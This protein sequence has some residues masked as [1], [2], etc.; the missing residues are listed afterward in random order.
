MGIMLSLFLGKMKGAL[1][2]AAVASAFIVGVFLY[3]V[4]TQKTRQRV[5]ELKRF[6]ET[7]DEI[8]SVDTDLSRKRRL[9]RLRRNG[10]IR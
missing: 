3:G 4:R 1:V 8:N 7:T 10:T 2:A 9:K 6:K 5:T